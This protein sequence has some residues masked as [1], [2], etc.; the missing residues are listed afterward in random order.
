[1]SIAAIS[2][3]AAISKVSTHTGS[4]LSSIPCWSGGYARVAR[5]ARIRQESSKPVAA[6]FCDWSQPPVTATNQR[7]QGAS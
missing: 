7:R 3:V 2:V 6:A 5:R 1:V 4:T